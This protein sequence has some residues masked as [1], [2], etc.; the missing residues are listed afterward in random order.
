MDLFRKKKA[1][2]AAAAAKQ[3]TAVSDFD[4]ELQRMEA[5]MKD[6]LSNQANASSMLAKPITTSSSPSSDELERELEELERQYGSSRGGDRAA[7]IS[8]VLRQGLKILKD[9]DNQPRTPDYP[10]LRKRLVG[11]LMTGYDA[12]KKAKKGARR[13]KRKRAT[14]RRRRAQRSS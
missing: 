11:I 9:L 6:L 5:Q 14:T 10:V 8:I 4:A 3:N 2:D 13:T 12:Y 1:A 7:S